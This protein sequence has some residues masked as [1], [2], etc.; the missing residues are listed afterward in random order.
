MHQ[1]NLALA[2]PLYRIEFQKNRLAPN[3]PRLFENLDTWHVS[4]SILEFVV[5]NMPFAGGVS[6][7]EIVEAVAPCVQE[8]DAELSGTQAA[9][10]AECVLDSLAN[11]QGGYKKFVKVFFD[12]ETRSSRKFMFR[13]LRLVREGED[14]FKYVITPEGVTLYLSML[15]VDPVSREEADQVMLDHLIATDKFS[16]AKE[17][18][19]RT[20]QHC[21]K[22]Q[23]ELQD[24]AL[25]MRNDAGRV[26]LIQDVTPV[27]NR[28]HGLIRNRIDFETRTLNT[29]SE[30]I[31]HT[32][33]NARTESILLMELLQ[34]SLE[35]KNRLMQDTL[36]KRNL[37]P[38]LKQRAF[39]RRSRSHLPDMKENVLRPMLTCSFRD[40]W[41]GRAVV[42]GSLFQARA[43]RIADLASMFTL[44]AGAPSN[45]DTEEGF[46]VS[47]DGVQVVPRV[48]RGFSPEL[49]RRVDDRLAPWLGEG[50]EFRISEVLR[51]LETEGFDAQSVRYAA[52][53]LYDLFWSRESRRMYRPVVG[54]VFDNSALARAED[55]EFLH[56]EPVPVE[57]QP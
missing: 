31:P 2:E 38:L 50:A 17:Y 49:V 39:A 9:Q 18:A 44:A 16:E 56:R 32:E 40:L 13:L 48:D 24:L 54:D 35:Y 23:G 5:E 19:R 7:E 55:I 42:L 1:H 28:A 37:F 33:G 41:D 15:T 34:E 26:N 3:H 22:L 25:A 36:E 29:L 51:T 43:P 14:R 10:V 46:E 6:R 12:R 57:S 21:V 53:V 4:L 11:H 47:R 20:R 8:M 27:L 52:M 45:Q 30:K